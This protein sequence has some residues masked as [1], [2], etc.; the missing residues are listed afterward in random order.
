MKSAVPRLPVLLGAVLITLLPGCHAEHEGA[1]GDASSQGSFF[2]SGT[3]GLDL[4][5]FL[6]G[7]PRTIKVEVANPTGEP[8]RF[9]A[10]TSCNCT[11]VEPAEFTLAAGDGRDLEIT[12]DPWEMGQD[13]GPVRP[14]S[15]EVVL[16]ANR[17]LFGSDRLR[18]HGAVIAPVAIDRAALTL[19]HVGPDGLPQTTS[20]PFRLQGG[21][22]DVSAVPPTTGPLQA[23]DVRWVGDDEY[24]LELTPSATLGIGRHRETVTL[25]ATGGPL[26]DEAV[27]LPVVVTASPPYRLSPGTVYFSE[28][29]LRTPE[30]VS[31]EGLRGFDVRVTEADGADVLAG[32]RSLRVPYPESGARGVEVVLAGRKGDGEG[33]VVRSWEDSIS[34]ILSSEKR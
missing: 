1:V 24:V 22:E 21:A 33:E 2:Q 5:Q 31:V 32:G 17:G 19:D 16:T 34:V 18:L 10:H 26:G 13:D 15:A 23:A 29:G 11:G 20:V 6:I 28:G 9:E 8:V 3:G 27:E 12:I 4:G 30:A 14:F 25:V 7:P